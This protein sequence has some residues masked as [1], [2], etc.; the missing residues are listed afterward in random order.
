MLCRDGDQFVTVTTEFIS[1]ALLSPLQSESPRDFVQ[2]LRLFIG[3]GIRR[4]P[5]GQPFLGH[6]NGNA[7]GLKRCNGSQ[8]VSHHSFI[9]LERI[10][11]DR[12][13]HGAY[14]IEID[15]LSLVT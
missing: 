6:G 5:V 3:D 7:S 4:G 10:V 12:F 2:V 14:L 13:Y 11:R 15:A 1:V 8:K 9:G